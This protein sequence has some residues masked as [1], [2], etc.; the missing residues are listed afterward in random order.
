MIARES[1]VN[2]RGAIRRW[3]ID[4][5]EQLSG[6][7]VLG[8]GIESFPIRRGVVRALIRGNEPE[9]TQPIECIY[10]PRGITDGSSRI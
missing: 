8:V 2:R 7:I 5:P 6:R 3:T 4:G 1:G 10:L 9:P